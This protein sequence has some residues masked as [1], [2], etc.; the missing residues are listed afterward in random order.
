MNKAV[1][2]VSA[3]GVGASL[4]YLFDPD[5]GTGRRALIRN[6]VRHAWQF[7]ASNGGGGLDRP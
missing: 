7:M 2:L 3:G 6:R 5:R 4:M 1:G